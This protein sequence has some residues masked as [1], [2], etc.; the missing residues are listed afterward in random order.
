MK[1]AQKVDVEKVVEMIK[2]NP[3]IVFVSDVYQVLDM[4]RSTFYRFYPTSSDE[5][6]TIEEALEANKTLTKR[7]IR[8]RL[9]ESKTP[10]SLIFLYK[11]L[12]TDKK[13]RMFLDGR[14]PEGD[15]DANDNVE[16]KIE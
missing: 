5:Y 16:L 13:E 8:D 3:K 12:T 11:I 10:A 6:N 7:E 14:C 9:K 4:C 1:V 15:P 2:S